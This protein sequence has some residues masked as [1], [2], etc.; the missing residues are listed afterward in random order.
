MIFFFKKRRLGRDSLL[1]LQSG[2]RQGPETEKGNRMMQG[3]KDRF[4]VLYEISSG[5]ISFNRMP[6]KNS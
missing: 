6:W 2:D 5:S 4:T 3:K 1:S